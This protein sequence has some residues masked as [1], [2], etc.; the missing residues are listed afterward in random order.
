MHKVS[1][2]E[3][4]RDIPARFLQG[5]PAQV[6]TDIWADSRQVGAGHAFV[7][8]RGTQMDGHAF[9][10]QA[11]NQ[12]ATVI[13]GETFDQPLLDGVTYVQVPDMQ[14]HLSQLMANFFGRPAEALTICGVTGTNGKTTTATLLYQLLTGL[15]YNTGLISTVAYRIGPEVLPSTHTTP[16]A[17]Q[18]QALF[19]RMVD[20]GCSHVCMEVSSH[21]LDQ[22]RV[23]G[24]PFR[25]A[26]F[27]NITH[28]HLDYHGTFQAY[29]KAKKRLFDMLAPE[30]VAIVN[31]D[32]RN[33]GVMVQN[34]RA[35]VRRFALRQDADYKARIL[36]NT[37]EGLFMEI[38]I[39]QVW[40]R[41]TG[42]FNA[43]NL[44]MVYAAALELGIESDEALRVLSALE[45]ADGRFQVMRGP[46][47]GPTAIVDYAHTPDALQ[48][49]LDT[50]LDINRGHA[51]VLAVVGCGGNRD[52]EKRPVMARI[53]AALADRVILTS[54]NPRYE[55]PDAIIEEMY[56]GVPDEH[57]RKVLKITARREAIRTAC[58]LAQPGD[59][60]LVAG[61][62]HETYQEIQGIKHPF[63]DREIIR[64][65]WSS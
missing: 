9:I 25:V 48:N 37:L 29:I 52:R 60:L 49:V 42:S 1:L 50:I 61:K 14:A 57:R 53:A 26:M 28:D 58:A 35:A 36:E 27:T 38:G 7:A 41:L 55:D 5:T 4:L 54:D 65:T 62:G 31:A 56:A 6:V 64:E 10:G 30:A 15:G 12:G 18:L 34:T 45:G 63:D 24:V 39:R 11:I 3:L 59:I 2:T 47:G 33:A 22:G 21:A 32:D 8:V 44:L 40:F 20:A 23:T 46:G 17:R 13:L 51:H 43:W 16:D 19:R